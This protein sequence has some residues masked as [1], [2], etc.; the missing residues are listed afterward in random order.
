LEQQ[1]SQCKS[2]LEDA[3]NK[4]ELAFK[5]IQKRGEHQKEKNELSHKALIDSIESR[6]KIT[7]KDLEEKYETHETTIQ[8]ERK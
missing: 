4:F 3:H 6:Y 7:L 2:D 5:Q 1:K 8:A